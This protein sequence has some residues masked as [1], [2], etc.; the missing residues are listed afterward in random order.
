MD[1]DHTSD[2]GTGSLEAALA[3]ARAQA[4]ATSA[5]QATVPSGAA[6]DL[7]AG[8]E[9]AAVVWDETLAAGG[10]A[11]AALR[12]G[13][14]LRVTDT[15]GDTCVNLQLFNAALP[16]ERLNPADTVKVQWQAYLG[17]GALILSDRGRVLATMV[18]DTSGRHDA[19]CGH[20]NR[21]GNEAR[22]GHGGAHGPT[23]NTRDLLALGA[24]RQGLERRDLTAG[25]NLFSTVVV[26]ED[27]ALHLDPPRQVASYVE[28]RAELDLV[29]VLAVAPH[30]LDDRP[31]YTAGPVRLS[32][33]TADRAEPDPFRTSSPE[34][35]RA[36][37]NTE[38]FLLAGAR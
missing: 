2:E 27:G 24:A 15:S 11:T 17:E 7:P 3:H 20:A 33:W 10:Y 26:A 14:V 31:A 12:R 6:T 25:I 4:G 35:Q 22:Y 34:R 13:T 28:L 37:E 23:P 29:V 19:L 36:F 8:V 38:Q 21:R 30:P 5:T 9:A 18:A 16:S 1:T 32:A